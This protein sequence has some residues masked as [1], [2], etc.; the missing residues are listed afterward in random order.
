M[1]E[2]TH[3][4]PPRVAVN[5]VDSAIEFGMPVPRVETMYEFAKSG[6]A[7]AT[8]KVS[9]G[10][11]AER[12]AA[13]FTLLRRFFRAGLKKYS[14]R[15]CEFEKAEVREI[16]TRN[17]YKLIEGLTRNEAEKPGIAADASRT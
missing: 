11:E 14:A 15:M 12:N 13:F 1:S 9:Y 3:K 4:Y 17:R 7:E 5:I 8:G 16:L 6:A 10:S 2:P